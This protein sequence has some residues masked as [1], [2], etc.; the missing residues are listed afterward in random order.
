M[1]VLL[2]LSACV[3]L[4]AAADVTVTTGTSPGRCRNAIKNA[5]EGDVVTFEPGTYEFAGKV[6]LKY[7]HV[8]IKAATPGTVFFDR[9]TSAFLLQGDHITFDGFTFVGGDKVATRSTTFDLY[10]SFNTLT[11]LDF[12]S[13][14][15]KRYIT[16]RP[17]GQYNTLSYSNFE[18]RPWDMIEGNLIQVEVSAAAP[19]FHNIHH[20][21]FQNINSPA[22]NPQVDICAE[23]LAAGFANPPTEPCSIGDFGN[24]PI[25]IGSS[26]QD[27]LTSNTIV[28]HC[29]FNNLG[30][31][32]GESISIKSRG[33]VIRFNTFEDNPL[34]Q[35]VVRSGSNTVVAGNFFIRSGGVRVKEQNDVW[36]YNNYFDQTDCLDHFSLSDG[37]ACK[38]AIQ[39]AYIADF[40]QRITVAHNTF[41]NLGAKMIS[42]D[43]N[44]GAANSI[45]PE[46]L[47]VNNIFDGQTGKLTKNDNGSVKWR[48]NLLT[49]V[50]KTGL[51]A[52]DGMD[53]AASSLVEREDGLFGVAAGSPAIDASSADWPA[54]VD[55]ELSGVEFDKLDKDVFGLPR[56]GGADNDVGANELCTGDACTETNR[57]LTLADVGPV[58]LRDGSGAA[59]SRRARRAA[60]STIETAAEA[61]TRAFGEVT[62]ETLQAVKTMAQYGV[63]LADADVVAAVPASTIYLAE[64]RGSGG[65]SWGFAALGVAVLALAAVAVR[66]TPKKAAMVDEHEQEGEPRTYDTYDGQSSTN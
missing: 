25:R 53:L 26:A 36:V 22:D 58:W 62:P 43:R 35:V 45:D 23:R 54:V 52:D 28:E 64:Q 15:N 55:D 12:D 49:G 66:R 20:C 42:L 5:R 56:P 32:D 24:E 41:R 30:R 48:N 2:C 27:E 34:G 57:P 7:D 4:A 19:G 39:L 61:A 16:F 50:S 10:G 17:G 9:K 46:V 63:R 11:N 59:T 31:A 51:L 3:A 60:E 21:S 37:E 6:K 14:A 1:R 29:Y 38:P 18:N 65:S 44:L 33:N 8:V 13:Y 40:T 47:F